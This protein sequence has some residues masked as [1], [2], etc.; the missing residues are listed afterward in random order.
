MR[1]ARE[2]RAKSIRPLFAIAENGGAHS[3][4]NHEMAFSVQN[5]GHL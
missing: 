3:G 5:L 4:S 2:Q 1:T